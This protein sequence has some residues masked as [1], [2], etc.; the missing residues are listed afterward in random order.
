MTRISLYAL[1]I[2]W[3]GLASSFHHRALATPEG[4]YSRLNNVITEA[5]LV[6]EY[7]SFYCPAC[8][9]YDNDFKVTERVKERLP[10][11]T[12]LTQY[13]AR[14]MGPLGDELTR[15]WSIAILMGIEDKVKPLLFDAV[16]VKKS[17][18]SWTD[19][20]R[21]FSSA[22]VPGSEFDAAWESFAVISL[23]DKQN[24]LASQLGLVS[25]PAIYIKGKYLINSDELDTSSI[26]TFSVSYAETVKRLLSDK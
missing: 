25:I 15:A 2:V 8:Y 24:A 26:D 11:G 13:H 19:I 7:F 1:L 17:V 21:V 10:E 5:P 14:F 4:G 23:T 6:L 22:G 18:H 20:R 12:K 16:Q 3:G 9:R